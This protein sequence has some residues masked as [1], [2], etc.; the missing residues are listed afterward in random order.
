MH[1]RLRPQRPD[2]QRAGLAEALRRGVFCA[3]GD[4]DTDIPAVMA[5]LHEIDYSGWLVV[6][7]DQSLH[8]DMTR[9]QLVA[10][11]RRN[12]HYLASLGL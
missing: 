3:L 11:Q 9:A 6:E 12:L 10:G 8:A 4:G 2:A 5:A 7:Q 1:D